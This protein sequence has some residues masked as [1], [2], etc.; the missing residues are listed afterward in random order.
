MSKQAS[1]FS[2]HNASV[3]SPTPARFAPAALLLVSA[4]TLLSS[5]CG[6][7][8]YVVYAPP[9]YGY[10]CGYGYGYGYGFISTVAGTGVAGNTGNGSPAV[11]AQLRQPVALTVDPSG[12]LYIADSASNTV[13]EVAAT[14][15]II[16]G[17]SSGITA[18]NHGSLTSLANNAAAA[19]RFNQ[20]SAVAIDASGNV[21]V[22]DNATSTVRRMSSTGVLSIVAGNAAGI[23]GFSGDN[24]QAINAKLN[25][26]LGMAFDPS[27]NVFIADT[28]NQR[29]RRVDASTGIITTVAG[30]GNAGYS[31]DGGLAA[32]AQISHPAA[33]ATDSQGNLYI[34]DSGNAAIRKVDVR[35]GII[36][37]VA[38]TGIIGFSG[39]NAAAVAAKLNQPLG[40]TVDAHNNLFISDTGNQ[41][42]REVAANT[43]VIS[44]IAGDSKQGYSGD[45]G[46]SSSADLNQPYATAIDASGNLYIADSGNGVIRKVLPN[47]QTATKAN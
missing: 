22:L 38:G 29:I 11:T 42:I 14:T 9:C 7:P 33:I 5:G 31:G 21:D 8:A 36:S 34:A 30:T 6:G 4:L 28:G 26:P 47:P 18:A 17:A 20:P 44:T 37:T 46:P 15:G 27:G 45:G 13:R 3:A 12:N 1:F 24:G 35:T 43:G 40:I 23:A 32:A 2:S 19:P 10:G 39:D 16:N 25:L 41:R